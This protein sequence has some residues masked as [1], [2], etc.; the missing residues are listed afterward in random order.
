MFN[1]YDFLADHRVMI[2]ELCEPLVDNLRE[3]FETVEPSFR[4]DLLEEFQEECK[5]EI[6]EYISFHL[7]IGYVQI[8]ETLEDVNIFTYL[9]LSI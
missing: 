1:L 6:A 2:S 3:E 9:D 8:Q 5:T 4:D 7:G